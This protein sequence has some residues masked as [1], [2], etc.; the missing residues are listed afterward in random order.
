MNEFIAY[1]EENNQKYVGTIQKILVEG[2]S[3]N[4]EKIEEY[5][6]KFANPYVAASYGYVDAIIQP[7]ETRDYLVHALEVCKNKVQENPRK[8]H[9]LPPF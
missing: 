9:G 1:L 4:N 3:K 6:Q 8:K 5:K 2:Q 7:N